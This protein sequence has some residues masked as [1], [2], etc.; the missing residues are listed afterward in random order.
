MGLVNNRG[1]ISFVALS[2]ILRNSVAYIPPIILEKVIVGIYT[3]P[4]ARLDTNT[5]VSAVTNGPVYSA[6]QYRIA[7][8][9]VAATISM[10]IPAMAGKTW[11]SA[12]LEKD[13][14]ETGQGWRFRG[15]SPTYDP[16]STRTRSGNQVFQLPSNT[17]SVTLQALFGT[18]LIGTL[19]YVQPVYM[20]VILL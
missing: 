2:T 12:R 19:K 6:S 20:T 13:D 8:P 10:T 18:G 11:I 14:E 4:V 3:L 17:G 5:H 1:L 7:T 9:A 15:L 16:L